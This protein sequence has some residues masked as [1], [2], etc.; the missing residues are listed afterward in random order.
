MPSLF[1]GCSK[2]SRWLIDCSSSSGSSSFF[3]SKGGPG[4]DI[5]CKRSTAYPSV[6]AKLPLLWV[7]SKPSQFGD[8]APIAPFTPQELWSFTGILKKP[9]R[10]NYSGWYK[11]PPSIP[12]FPCE[13]YLDGLEDFLK[14]GRWPGILFARKTNT[15]FWECCCHPDYVANV[16]QMNNPEK[17]PLWKQHL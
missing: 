12:N 1:C 7:H 6:W 14:P 2:H 8:W 15:S 11:T 17:S 10:R 5:S 9:Q 3:Q 16:S 13:K 4:H